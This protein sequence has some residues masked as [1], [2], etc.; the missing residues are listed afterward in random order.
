MMLAFYIY[1]YLLVTPASVAEV[2]KEFDLTRERTLTQLRRLEAMGFIYR[3]RSDHRING[4]RYYPNNVTIG[5]PILF[6]AAY[7]RMEALP[8]IP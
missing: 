4:V 2:Q 6:T 5:E 7:D 1:R 3:K 8:V